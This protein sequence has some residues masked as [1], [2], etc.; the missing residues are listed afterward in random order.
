MI[1]SSKNIIVAKNNPIFKDFIERLTQKFFDIN[2]LNLSY[3]KWYNFLTK[4]FYTQCV[5]ILRVLIFASVKKLHFASTNF[6]QQKLHSV[7]VDDSE[8][9]VLLSRYKSHVAMLYLLQHQCNNVMSSKTWQ[10]YVF[11]NVNLMS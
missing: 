2:K 8:C 7:F 5:Y 3:I 6:L 11:F 4:I 10:Y 9:V 1:H